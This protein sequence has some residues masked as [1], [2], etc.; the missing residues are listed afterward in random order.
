MVLAQQSATV[1]EILITPLVTCFMDL[2][3]ELGNEY[4]GVYGNA[5]SQTMPMHANVTEVLELLSQTFARSP[6]NATDKV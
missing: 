2:A 3:R 4:H 6:A 5:T 1:I